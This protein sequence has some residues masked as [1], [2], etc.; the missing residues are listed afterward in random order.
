MDGLMKLKDIM[1]VSF[2][3]ARR[4]KSSILIMFLVMITSIACLFSLS[5]EHAFNTYWDTYINKNPELRIRMVEYYKMLN[6]RIVKGDSTLDPK[7]KLKMI[8][9]TTKEAKQIIATNEHIIAI[10]QE[11]AFYSNI[12]ELETENLSGDFEFI[13]VPLKNDIPLIAGENLDAYN[14]KDKVMICPNS[15]YLD[16]KDRSQ[17]VNIEK[18]QVNFESYLGKTLKIKVAYSDE[19]EEYKVIGLFDTIDTYS[20][21]D[22]CYMSQEN[23][24]YLNEKSNNANPDYESYIDSWHNNVNYIGDNFYITLDNM[25][26]LNEVQSFLQEHNMYSNEWIGMNTMT[27][28]Q[29]MDTCSKISFG[30]LI[31]SIIVVGINLLQNL[32]KRKKEFYLYHTL[33]YT[34]KDIIKI[35]FMENSILILIGF[36]LAIGITQIGLTIYKNTTLAGIKRLYLMNPQVDIVSILISFLVSLIIPI[37]ITVFLLILTRKTNLNKR[38]E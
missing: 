36:I 34:Q 25:K 5:Y 10:N 2:R 38:K 35:I 32:E 22:R 6:P 19:L 33:G 28:E 30:C 21:G 4:S 3:S 31:L 12:P 27:V 26:N 24:Q 13:S 29:T 14:E 23:I 8:D 15:I 1:K 11:I 18:S 9:E 7:E 16:P 37:L 17:S 20:I